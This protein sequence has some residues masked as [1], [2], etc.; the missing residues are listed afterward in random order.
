MSTAPKTIDAPK[1]AATPAPAAA[2][3]SD[4]KPAPPPRTMA[5]DTAIKPAEVIRNVWATVAPARH[6]FEEAQKPWYLWR[7]HQLM[8]AG[9]LFEIR[10]ELN[11]YFISGLVLEIDRDTQSITYKPIHVINLR[12]VEAVVADLT[13]AVIEEMGANKWSVRLGSQVMKTGF[14]TADKARDWVAEKQAQG[15]PA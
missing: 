2:P 8:K 13:G 14:A 11:E 4:L 1:P 6:S 7:Q 10:H 12:E 15:R 3:A 9:D 5:H